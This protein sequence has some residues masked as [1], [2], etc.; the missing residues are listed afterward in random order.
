MRNYVLLGAMLLSMVAFSQRKELKS[1]EKLIKKGELVQ[2]QNILDAVQ[3]DGDKYASKYYYLL[4]ELNFQKAKNGVDTFNAFRQAFKNYDKSEKIDKEYKKEIEL[5][6]DEASKIVSEKAQKLYESQDF[7]PS[8][9]AFEVLYRISPID[10]VFLYNAAILKTQAKQYAQ[11]IDLFKELRDIGYDGSEI[12]YLAQNKE[13]G[14]QDTFSNKAQ[15]DLMVKGGTHTAPQDKKTESKRGTIIRQMGQI[16]K[17]Q[18]KIDEAIALMDQAR[19]MFPQDA[20]LLIDEAYIYYQIGDKDKFKQLLQDASVL[21]PENADIQYNIGV[22]NL[23]QKDYEAAREAFK[24]AL[25]IDPAYSNAALNM[26][27]TYIREGNEIAEQMNNLGN[28]AADN[29]KYE[30]LKVEKDALFAKAASVLE[31][32]I[33]KNP[34]KNQGILEQL[35]S[36]Y[37]SLGDSENFKRIKQLLE[38]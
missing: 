35:K 24:A 18:G 10:T 1:A 19:S 28:S 29:V 36:I 14:K 2:A 33:S 38:N 11:A 20:S 13:T 12:I 17:E 27:T 9:T 21:E 25:E 7:D 5:R 37:Y 30:K 6:R 16:Y 32:Y 26:S 3:L 23:D 31:D 8:A 4:G 34:G 15:R 22:I